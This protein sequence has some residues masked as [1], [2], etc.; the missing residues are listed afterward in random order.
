MEG[1]E[2]LEPIGLRKITS[3]KHL[4]QDK[5]RRTVRLEA[6]RQLLQSWAQLGPTTPKKRCDLERDIGFMH[7]L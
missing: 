4:S 3:L 1:F 6:G 2:H 7:A 5:T